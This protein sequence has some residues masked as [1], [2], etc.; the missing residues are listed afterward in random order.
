MLPTPIIF[1]RSGIKEFVPSSFAY[2]CVVKL[3]KLQNFVIATKPTDLDINLSDSRSCAAV[4]QPF[5]FD[6]TIT[7]DIWVIATAHS[8]SPFAAAR[9]SSSLN[10]PDTPCSISTSSLA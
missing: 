9:R 5:S 7:S 4:A 2:E 3:A 8:L 6:G 10:G 1:R